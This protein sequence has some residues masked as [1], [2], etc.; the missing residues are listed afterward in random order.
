[1]VRTK[2]KVKVV[3]VIMTDSVEGKGTEES[4]VCVMRRYWT[5]EGKL[6]SEQLYVGENAEPIIEK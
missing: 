5:L 6:I 1:M 4:P 2:M 3:E